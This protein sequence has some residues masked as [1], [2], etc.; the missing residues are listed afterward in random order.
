MVGHETYDNASRKASRGFS[1]FVK[2]EQIPVR[3]FDPEMK[4][5]KGEI[6]ETNSHQNKLMDSF[7]FR[8]R[9]LWIKSCRAVWPEAVFSRII[10]FPVLL[11]IG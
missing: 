11:T 1:W 5:R 9:D 10:N 6:V 3:V 7:C 2:K 8:S 4:A